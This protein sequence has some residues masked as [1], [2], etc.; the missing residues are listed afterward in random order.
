M[1]Y[2]CLI[3]TELLNFFFFFFYWPSELALLD[4][5]RGQAVCLYTLHDVEF[6]IETRTIITNST[7]WI[8]I[9]FCVMW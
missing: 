3:Q 2:G 8:R 4:G 6:L 7:N 9:F 1:A 5:V